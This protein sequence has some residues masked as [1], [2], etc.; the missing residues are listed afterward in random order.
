MGK[1]DN[2]WSSK[3][4]SEKLAAHIAC[5]WRERGYPDV[6][7]WV[8]NAVNKGDKNFYGV[9]SNIVIGKDGFPVR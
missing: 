9:R 7:T 8:V 2:D 4:K 3:D 6:K 1:W 5:Y